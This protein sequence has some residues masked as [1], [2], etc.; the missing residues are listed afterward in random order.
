[1]KFPRN[2]NALTASQGISQKSKASL[3]KS[4]P[5]SGNNNKDY[6]ARRNAAACFANPRKR[7]EWHPD[8][9]GV[10]VLEGLRTGDKCWVNVRERISR[11]TG[12]RYLSVYLRPQ[13]VRQ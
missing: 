10:M 5:G 4:H 11:K 6:E 8:F 13:E 2:E 9:T 3:N 7:E 12:K 1:M